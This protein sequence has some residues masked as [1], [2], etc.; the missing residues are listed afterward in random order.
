[1][2]RVQEVYRLHGRLLFII[3]NRKVKGIKQGVYM[4]RVFV[5][6]GAVF[7]V[8]RSKSVICS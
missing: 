1:M 6:D 5:A 4:L 8:T 2:R 3:G 7:S